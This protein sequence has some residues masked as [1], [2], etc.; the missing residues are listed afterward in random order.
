MAMA[1]KRA[2]EIATRVAS[3]EKGNG[4]KEGNG[5]SNKGSPLQRG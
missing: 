5:N 2:M 4:D 3:N 1:M